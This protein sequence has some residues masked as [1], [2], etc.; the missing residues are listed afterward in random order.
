[1]RHFLSA[2]RGFLFVSALLTSIS[3]FGQSA[4]SLST[5]LN[6]DGSIRPDAVG[7]F[8]PS[9]Y[10]LAYGLNGEPRFLSAPQSFGTC[11]PDAWDTTFTANGADNEVRVVVSDG[12]GNFYIA[13]D[14]NSVNSVPASRIAK[15]NGTT[16]SALGSGITGSV[17]SIAFSGTD[18]YVGGQFIDRKS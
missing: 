15:W 16:W 2:A 9:G 18:V 17:N 13:G 4:P 14:F 3:A 5:A 1:M 8:D 10:R 11:T 7:S 12:A 6:A